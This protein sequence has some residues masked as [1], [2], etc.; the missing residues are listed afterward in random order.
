MKTNRLKLTA[1]ALKSRA[2]AEETLRQFAEITLHRNQAQLDMDAELTAI[3]ERYQEALAKY[4]T[5]LGE[6]TETLRAWA[7]AN[8]AEF[9]GLKTLQLT[10]GDLGWRIGQPTLKTLAGWTWDRVLEKIKSDLVRWSG[11]LRIKEEVN[12]QA[13]LN[14]RET[15]AP[16]TLRALGVRVIQEEG[17]FVDPK[18]EQPENRQQS[19]EQQ[20]A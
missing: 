6:K 13:I 8:P 2:Q 17:F 11:F 15:L 10:H 14:E 3:R 1:P 20:A 12:K 18:I 16:E 7:E 19:S 5:A 9:R 4:T